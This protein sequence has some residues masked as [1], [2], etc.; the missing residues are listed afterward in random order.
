MLCKRHE[1]K[2]RICG[3]E[4]WPR[5]RDHQNSCDFLK[6]SPLP[7]DCPSTDQAHAR[8][9]VVRREH[10]KGGEKRENEW[11]NGAGRLLSRCSDSTASRRLSVP[12]SHRHGEEAV[13][14]TLE[15]VTLW[16]DC[17][18]TSS[19]E[20]LPGS[21]TSDTRGPVRWPPARTTTRRKKAPLAA[22]E[23][24]C[25]LQPPSY[26]FHLLLLH[27]HLVLLPPLQAKHVLPHYVP[28]S[29]RPRLLTRTRCNLFN[30]PLSWADKAWPPNTRLHLAQ[31]RGIVSHFI[32]S[33]AV[34]DAAYAYRFWGEERGGGRGGCIFQHLWFGREKKC[35]WQTLTV[36]LIFL[37]KALNVIT[38]CNAKLI[39][40]VLADPWSARNWHERYF[41]FAVV[42]D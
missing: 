41:F 24:R 8:P 15:S 42:I 29:A 26:V 39:I 23:E 28:V 7:L 36:R 21:D 13:A 6:V 37:T 32:T 10:R 14:P 20:Q 27:L 16:I 2:E 5:I 19:E 31:P 9:F 30:P 1:E 3:E 22:C 12:P 33:S 34:A 17:S 25:K 4:E 18:C 40:C 38:R 35:R 11:M